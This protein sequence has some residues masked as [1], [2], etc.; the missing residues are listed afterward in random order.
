VLLNWNLAHSGGDFKEDECTIHRR[1]IAIRCHW[2]M[3]RRWTINNAT[4]QEQRMSLVDDWRHCRC[5]S[6]LKR[7][8]ATSMGRGKVVFPQ[9]TVQTFPFHLML[10]TCSGRSEP[11]YFTSYAL[12]FLLTMSLSLTPF[13]IFHLFQSS[14]VKLRWGTY[15]STRYMHDKCMNM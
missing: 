9:K 10:Y 14:V 4:E 12:N 5:C 2:K 6:L 3:W 7:R 13:F 8:G 15:L 11:S 1:L